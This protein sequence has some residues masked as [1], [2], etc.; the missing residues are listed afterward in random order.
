MAKPS[1]FV[2]VIA[3]LK[4]RNKMDDIKRRIG[5]KEFMT[6]LGL[7]LRTL[8][9][10]DT[11]AGKGV[12]SDQEGAGV[13]IRLAALSDTYVE[14]RRKKLNSKNFSPGPFFKVSKSNLTFTGQMLESLDFEARQGLVRVF[15]SDTSR[16]ELSGRRSKLS[17]KDVAD[18]VTRNGRPFLGLSQRNERTLDKEIERETRAIVRREL[19]R[20]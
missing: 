2:Q 13:E 1:I 7:Q 20:K 8:I 10:G 17:N 11:K 12:A 19:A 3:E 18:I 4:F 15:V 9:Y 16:T 5:R 6:K 14:Y